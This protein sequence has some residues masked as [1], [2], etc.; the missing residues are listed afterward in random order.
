LDQ[1][2]AAIANPYHPPRPGSDDPHQGIDI[3]DMQPGQ[4][5]AL[6]GGTVQ[7]V[8]AG[9]VAMVIQNRFPYGNAILIE[10]PLD[11]LPGGWASSIPF[12]TLAPTI[13][14][15][16]NLTCPGRPEQN[17]DFSRRSLYLLYA[18]MQQAPAF[19][20]GDPINCGQSIGL[21]GNSGNALNPHLHLEARLGPSG[22]R[23]G[24]LAH[25]DSSASLDEMENY[26]T[27]R[28]KGVFQLLDPMIILAQP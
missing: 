28:V 4:R 1:I 15:L 24:S 23:P 7:S 8:L 26:C 25:Y 13:V 9:Q 6:A 21:V 3:A 10:T 2:Q 22:W 14:P 17:W 20:P 18:H 12:P 5:I 27:W 11:S 16:P 19:Q